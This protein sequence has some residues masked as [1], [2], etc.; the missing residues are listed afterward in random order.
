MNYFTLLFLLG[1]IGSLLAQPA[2]KEKEAILEVLM[3]QQQHWNEGNLVAFMQGYWKSDSLI[4]TGRNGIT[5]GWE[6]VLH[7]YQRS[8]PSHEAMG[9]LTFTVLQLHVY[10][11]Q[12]ALLVG[13]W[14]LQRT[15]DEPG[16]FFTLV[17]R[18]IRGKW[19]IVADHTS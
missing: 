8:Y 3:R 17:W 10:E 14:K 18:K 16:G 6:T 9:K 12:T 4:F 7:N 1:V 19:V 11:N 13:Q 5:L 2:Q 15:Q